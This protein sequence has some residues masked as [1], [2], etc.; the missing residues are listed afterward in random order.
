MDVGGGWG[1]ISLLHFVRT[2]GEVAEILHVVLG[3]LHKVDLEL[4]L[5]RHRVC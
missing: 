2:D 1:V 4:L 3:V 5:R